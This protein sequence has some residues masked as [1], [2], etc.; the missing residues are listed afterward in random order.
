VNDQFSAA[1]ES[2]VAATSSTA[3]EQSSAF[4]GSVEIIEEASVVV[5]EKSMS[6]VSFMD[7]VNEGQTSKATSI[8]AAMRKRRAVNHS[9]VLTDSPYKNTLSEGRNKK[10]C[11]APVGMLAKPAHLIKKKTSA[12]NGKAG[13]I[14]GSDTA[15]CHTCKEKFCDDFSGR[16]WIQCQLCLNWFHNECQGLPEKNCPVNFICVACENDS[17]D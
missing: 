10:T 12:R 9:T 2:T 15:P 4:T 11:K 17:D 8:G 3:N 5:E 1:L 13:K 6:N 14:K 16:K 7:I